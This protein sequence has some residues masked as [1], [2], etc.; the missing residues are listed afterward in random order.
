[1]TT[2]ALIS[3]L[4][5]STAIYFYLTIGL[6]SGDAY[7][8]FLAIKTSYA[9]YLKSLMAFFHSLI[10]SYYVSLEFA[11]AQIVFA[12]EVLELATSTQ[13]ISSSYSFTYNSINETE[14]IISA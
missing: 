11:K 8:S 4:S 14:N 9:W 2:A 6:L 13:L 3:F 12:S 10:I 7:L 1:M 5:F